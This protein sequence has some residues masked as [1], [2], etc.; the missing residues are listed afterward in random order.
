MPDQLDKYKRQLIKYEIERQALK[1]E[2]DAHSIERLAALEKEV[3]EL[4]EKSNELEI[5]WQTEKEIITEI[6]QTKKDI[7]KLKQEA[8][9][10]ERNV[11]LQ[12]VAEIRY[13][14]IPQ[15]EKSL[16]TQQNK[17]AK[18]QK[19]HRILKEEVT[20][21]DIANVVARWTGI[22][23]A[24]MMQT[25]LQKLAHAEQELSKR[26]VGQTEA[27]SVIANALRRSRVGIADE[28]RPIGSFLFVGPTG[29]GKTELARALAS[30]MFN[31]ERA[32]IRI[33]MSEYMERH[34]V[35]RLVGSPP[36]YVG[37]EEGGQLTE[38][39]RRRPY[40]VV[41]FDE[42]EKAHPEAFNIL[43]QVLDDGRLTDAKGRVV[44]F[45]NTI[46]I[47]TSN[48][49]T[50]AIQTFA[51]G[52]DGSSNSAKKNKTDRAYEDMRDRIMDS[53]KSS[54]KP[55]FINRLD[56]IVIFHH[57]AK[58]HL[59]T[60]VDLQLDVARQRLAQRDV[61]ITVSDKAKDYLAEKGFS[62]V[63]GA[64]PLKRLIQQDILDPLAVKLIDGSV[65]DGDT[66]HIDAKKN[67]LI[68]S[69]EK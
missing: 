18:I 16:Q 32:L 66:V 33:D 56:D 31:D 17:L 8:D 63:Y 38:Q 20:E 36:G 14:R 4:K 10:A 7:E 6:R 39:V 11:D 13:G 50:E 64:R 45:K 41:L 55:E 54:F 25:D 9:I 34:A 57:L 30:F 53:I 27:I 49:G 43:L 40:S 3:S 15:L 60:I 48:V 44:N 28:R 47:L 23:V 35:S 69:V 21:E 52:F 24:K 1:R 61:G 51:I 62:A 19:D 65:K 26:I 46:V 12:K 58:D 22:P 42:V 67:A 5:Q 59:R 2:S 68:L 29:V 37:Y